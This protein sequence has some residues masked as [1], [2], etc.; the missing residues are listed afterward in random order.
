MPTMA[1]A[2]REASDM[3]LNGLLDIQIAV[4]NPQELFDFWLQHGMGATADGVL[5]TPDRPVQMQIAEGTYRHL[6]SMH[7]SCDT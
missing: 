2:A 6:S 1:A 5:G 7:L 3:A 4:P